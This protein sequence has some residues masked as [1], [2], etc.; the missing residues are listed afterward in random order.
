MTHLL[1]T[2]RVRG[3]WDPSEE[4]VGYLPPKQPGGARPRLLLPHGPWPGLRAEG[5]IGNELSTAEGWEATMRVCKGCSTSHATSYACMCLTHVHT[6]L[7]HTHARLMRAHTCHTH[8]H[9]CS[10]HVCTPHM[11][12]TCRHSHR[13]SH[14]PLCALTHASH[15][16]TLN[17]HA[18]HTCTCMPHMHTHTLPAAPEHRG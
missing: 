18:L 3:R 16:L 15:A 2:L 9:S 8:T 10:A 5:L 4:R 12:L 14:I 11:C 1:C 6:C 13:Q 17:A 7:T